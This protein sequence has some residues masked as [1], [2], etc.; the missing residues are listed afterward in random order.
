MRVTELVLGAVFLETGMI[1]KILQ[2]LR[3]LFF[4]V[5]DDSILASGIY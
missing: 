1:K 3:F 4:F 5:E 2:F